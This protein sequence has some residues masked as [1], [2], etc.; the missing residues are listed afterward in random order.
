MSPAAE[1]RTKWREVSQAAGRR[2][3]CWQ[4]SRHEMIIVS[5]DLYSGEW[6]DSQNNRTVGFHGPFTVQVSQ[7]VIIYS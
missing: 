2:K 5:I 6:K 1:F 3:G 4:Y 7:S